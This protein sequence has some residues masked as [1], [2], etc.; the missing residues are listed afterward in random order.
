MLNL[1]S[2]IPYSICNVV[3]SPNTG[4]TTAELVPLVKMSQ[5]LKS[6]VFRLSGISKNLTQ[7]QLHIIIVLYTILLRLLYNAGA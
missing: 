1:C 7:V 5:T 3:T 4:A 2:S 6:A